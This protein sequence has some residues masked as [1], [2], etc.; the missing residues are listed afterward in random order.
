MCLQISQVIYYDLR[1]REE[2][3]K[4]KDEAFEIE[5]LSKDISSD[6]SVDSNDND[7]NPANLE[8]GCTNMDSNHVNSPNS[9]KSEDQQC[10]IRREKQKTLNTFDLYSK[11]DV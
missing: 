5:C 4:A 1:K 11:Y 6:S 10:S 2:I 3:R 7:S 8:T 9:K